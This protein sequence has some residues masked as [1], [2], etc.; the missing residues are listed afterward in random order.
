[1]LVRRPCGRARPGRSRV[2]SPA[3]WTAGALLP[4][5]AYRLQ[6]GT[7]PDSI[8]ADAEDSVVAHLRMKSGVL[9]QLSY[10]PSGPGGN[11]YQRSLHG[12]LGSLEIP[13]DR[14]GGAV[15]LRRAGGTLTGAELLAELPG[16]QLDPVTTALF[17]PRGVTYRMDFA[18]ADAR[19][20]AIE[21]HDF[22][23][24]VLTGR[25]PEVSG[26]DGLAAVATILGAFESGRLGRPVSLDEIEHGRVSAAQDPLDRELGL[27]T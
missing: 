2:R 11:F 1:V 6:G 13:R 15:V 18:E 20:I 24:A 17:G 25:P 26:R 27:L 5:P 9:V 16:F 21:L 14:T 22:A 4:H 12:R 19:H 10:V 3:R 23:E 7:L 8:V